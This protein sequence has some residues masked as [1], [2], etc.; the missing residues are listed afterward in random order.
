MITSPDENV[1]LINMPTCDHLDTTEKTRSLLVAASVDAAQRSYAVGYRLPR[2]LQA[3]AAKSRTRIL[4]QKSQSD[5]S[6]PR[7]TNPDSPGC[8]RFPQSSKLHQLNHERQPF[9]RSLNKT[10]ETP[11]PSN[12]SPHSCQPQANYSNHCR[13]SL[14]QGEHK[15]R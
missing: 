7:R 12:D 10:S 5:P 15:S 13:T 11:Q 4:C 9:A 1:A 8:D 6:E 3:P 14:S 2:F